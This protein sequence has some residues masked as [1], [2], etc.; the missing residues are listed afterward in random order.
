MPTY[1][2]LVSAY[3]R[4]VVALAFAAGLR[5]VTAEEA[6]VEV[7]A[8]VYL[9]M[10]SFAGRSAFGTWLHQIAYRTILRFKS[11]HR[12]FVPLEPAAEPAVSIAPDSDMLLDERNR[13]LWYCVNRLPPREAMTIL[14]HYQQG[15][16]VKQISQFLDCPTGTVKTI[17]WRGRDKLK[18]ILR[19]QGLEDSDE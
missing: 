6:V 5:G 2:E 11:R 12:R 7:F 18:R 3:Q 17:L 1:E 14:W 19:E 13:K 9:S 15:Y 8:E 16:S 4:Q 10:P